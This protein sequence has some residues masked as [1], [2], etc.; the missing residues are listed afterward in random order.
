MSPSSPPGPNPISST[1]A[2]LRQHLAAITSAALSAVDAQRLTARG[3]SALDDELRT[4]GPVRVV[5][6]GKAAVGMAAAAEQWLGAHLRAGVLTAPASVQ[7]HKAWHVVAASH[8]QPN[9]E[10]EAAG[11]AALSLADQTLREH[12]L[13]LVCLSGGASA[14]LAVPGEGLTIADKAATTGCLLRAGLDISEINMVRRHLSAIKG[15]QLAARAGRVVTLAISDVCTPVEDDP[16]VIASGPTVGDA[17]SFDDALAVLDRHSL[18]G[19]I[20]AAALRHLEAGAAGRVGGPVP[21]GD[22]R[23]KS[24]AY[25]LVGSR[26]DAMTAARDTAARLGY[27]VHMERAPV[28]GEAHLA[29]PA[30]IARAVSYERPACV[31]ASG[32][33]TVH[34]RGSGHGGRNQELAVAALTALSGAAPAA[35]ASVGTDG[36]DGPT[37]AAG[38]F[39]TSDMWGA[40]GAGASGLVRD[41]LARNDTYPLLQQLEALVKT[42]PSGTNVGDL[43]ILLLDA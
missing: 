25:W 1:N 34:V 38:G 17:S 6:A 29:G 7:T 2:R 28:V 19:V 22:P 4:A 15:G 39:V 12:G 37:D 21:P 40:L 32:E 42:G 23:L 18:R 8:P 30:L 26:Q 13:L 36:V 9:A 33:T 20:P 11:R 41:A 43:Q 10:S 3:L 35:L 31:I 5:A 24:S 14:M 27:H 16:A